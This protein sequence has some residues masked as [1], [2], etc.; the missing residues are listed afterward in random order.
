[1]PGPASVETAPPPSFN[2]LHVEE[3]I[4]RPIPVEARATGFA[5]IGVVGDRAYAGL[6]EPSPTGG[7]AGGSAVGVGGVG[8]RSPRPRDGGGS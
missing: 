4:G 7:G 3:R 5:G 1:M 2:L 6:G 8:R